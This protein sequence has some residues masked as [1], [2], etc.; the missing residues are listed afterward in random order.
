MEAIEYGT[1]SVSRL[2]SFYPSSFSPA[3]LTDGSQCVYGSIAQAAEKKHGAESRGKVSSWQPA[4]VRQTDTSAAAAL[5][6]DCGTGRGRSLLTEYALGVRQARERENERTAQPYGTHLMRLSTSDWRRAGGPAA[7]QGRRLLPGEATSAAG[8]AASSSE[9]QG[10]AAA[11][12]QSTAGRG[13]A[14]FAVAVV[15]FGGGE[16]FLLGFVGR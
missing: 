7:G 9:G 1:V 2:S 10:P 11:V 12:A 3:A 14:L 15:V 6:C 4:E 5:F 13:L 8:C 16:D